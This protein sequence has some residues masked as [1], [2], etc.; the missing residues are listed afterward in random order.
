[1]KPNLIFIL[2]I[3]MSA[4]QTCG[5]VR[6]EAPSQR[7]AT[8]QVEGVDQVLAVVIDTSGSFDDDWEQKVYRFLLDMIDSYFRQSIGSRS[9]LQI[10][11]LSESG[12]PV[13]WIA[14]PRDFARAFP[15]EQAFRDRLAAEKQTAFSPIFGSVTATIK[16]V[17]ATAGLRSDGKATVV[18]LSDLRQAWHKGDA[19]AEAKGMVAA[20]KE[21]TEDGGNIAFYYAH[22]KIAISLRA[23][24]EKRGVDNAR[25]WIES[26]N[27]FAPTAPNFY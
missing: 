1:M 26:D 10:A 21:F 22:P 27:V 6:V 25:Y 9:V 16:S 11:V 3:A 12:D 8:L 7:G 20:I 14:S 15:D 23:G 19:D 24:L 4:L 13:F 17:Q 18:V 2:A 5:C